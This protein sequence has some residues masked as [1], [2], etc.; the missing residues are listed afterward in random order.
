MVVVAIK[1]M[2]VYVPL[3]AVRARVTIIAIRLQASKQDI[4]KPVIVQ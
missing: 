1:V 3:H 4:E 2:Q